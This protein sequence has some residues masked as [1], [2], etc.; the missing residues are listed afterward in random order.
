MK[1]VHERVYPSFQV[2]QLAA[3]SIVNYLAEGNDKFL[4]DYKEVKDG[5]RLKIYQG[6]KP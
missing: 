1:K 6:K 2:A 3:T 5:I 4:E